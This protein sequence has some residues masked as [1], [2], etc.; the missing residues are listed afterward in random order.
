MEMKEQAL[1]KFVQ[2]WPPGLEPNYHYGISKLRLS[3]GF[4]SFQFI[5]LLKQIK[6]MHEQEC[7]LGVFDQAEY[8]LV[9]LV[10]NMVVFHG[11]SRGNGGIIV[12]W[13]K[14]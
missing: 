13:I 2:Y 12:Q 7:M 10:D 14:P 1:L 3:I 8:G 6:C 9:K 11:N 5:Y 4:N